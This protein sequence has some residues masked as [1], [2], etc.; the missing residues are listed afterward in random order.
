MSIENPM[1]KPQTLT[2]SSEAQGNKPLSGEQSR[3]LELAQEFLKSNPELVKLHNKVLQAQ[4]KEPVNNLIDLEK[5][6][7]KELNLKWEAIKFGYKNRGSADLRKDIDVPRIVE[8]ATKGYILATK[9]LRN[10]PN[11]PEFKIRLQNFRDELNQQNVP[12]PKMDSK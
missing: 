11:N 2:Y 6:I 1:P 5:T 8:L 3:N 12:L 7:G 4:G 9:A 10:W